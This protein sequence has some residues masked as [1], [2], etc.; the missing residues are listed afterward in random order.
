MQGL[1][2]QELAAKCRLKPAGN[3]CR[4]MYTIILIQLQFSLR[5]VTKYGAKTT[6]MTRRNRWGNTVMLFECQCWQNSDCTE[7]QA[8]DTKVKVDDVSISGSV[9]D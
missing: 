9:N 5:S 6:W 3:L 4:W 1:K 7:H 2:E 8:D